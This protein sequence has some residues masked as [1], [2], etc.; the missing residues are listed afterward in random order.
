LGRTPEAVEQIRETLRL[1][2]NF[3]G[4]REALDALTRR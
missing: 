3:P 2:Q 1:D 4:A